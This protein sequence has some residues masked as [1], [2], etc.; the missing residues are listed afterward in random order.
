MTDAK[1]YEELTRILRQL[2]KDPALLPVATTG[3]DQIAG[4][5][6]FMQ[7]NIIVAVE[8]S[9][10]IRIGSGDASRLR[11]VGDFVQLIRSKTLS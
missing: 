11:T 10:G 8:D 5:N 1:I 2:L 4:W 3:A 6:S 7:I 9:F